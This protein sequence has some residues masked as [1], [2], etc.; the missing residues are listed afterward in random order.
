MS[1]SRNQRRRLKQAAA[2]R[3]ECGECDCC[4]DVVG[5][6]ELNKPINTRCE[7][8]NGKGCA[9]YAKRPRECQV[10]RCEW[11]MG[12]WP[13]A[14]RPDRLGV[15]LNGQKNP[16][17]GCEVIAYQTRPG[18]FEDAEAVLSDIARKAGPILLVG[19]VEEDGSITCAKMEA[20]GEQ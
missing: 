6:G 17:D 2:K 11:L 1:Q 14:L 8:M 4:C 7:H 9:I 10:Y 20:T 3:N 15:I 19:E 12:G 5:V 16:T 18:G 13:D